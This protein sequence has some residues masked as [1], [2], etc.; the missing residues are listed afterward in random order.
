MVSGGT[1]ATPS[2]SAGSTAVLAPTYVASGPGGKPAVQFSAMNL[3]IVS[4]SGSTNATP[5]G[6]GNVVIGYDEG[7]GAKTGSHNLIL[8][9]GQAYTSYG[10]II[11]GATNT[12]NAAEA[13]LF[14][15]QNTANAALASVTGGRMNTA[16]AN[17][18]AVTG[19]FD[20]RH[21]DRLQLGRRRLRQPRRP[22]QSPPVAEHL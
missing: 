15:Y 3:Q 1:A 21:L 5:T 13:V 4:G 16:G 12:D 20:N 7:S 18:T 19:G 2:C 10:S 14:G 9:R 11:A 8:G 22:W 6:V 17:F